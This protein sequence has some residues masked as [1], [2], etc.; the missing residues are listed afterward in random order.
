MGV[1]K[2]TEHIAKEQKSAQYKEEMIKA[3][4]E[5]LKSFISWCEQGIEKD[6]FYKENYRDLQREASELILSK[7]KIEKAAGT[8]QSGQAKIDINTLKNLF[9]FRIDELAKEKEA[10]QEEGNE[11]GARRAQNLSNKYRALI[12]QADDLEKMIRT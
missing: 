7:I 3:S 5:K 6:P 12:L 1:E 9:N 8:L 10:A 2:T 11:L 4:P